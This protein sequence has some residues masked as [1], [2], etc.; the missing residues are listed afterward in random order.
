MF[1]KFK[2][3]RSH[4]ILLIQFCSFN[5]IFVVLTCLDNILSTVHTLSIH[6]Q[7]STIDTIKYLKLVETTKAELG[8][9]RPDEYFSNFYTKFEITSSN[10]N[11]SL[12]N[13]KQQ[14]TNIN[15]TLTDYIITSTTGF[16]NTDITIQNMRVMYLTVCNEYDPS[17]I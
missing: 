16:K 15:S 6:L 17:T 5:I 14:H 7:S 11:I 9:W 2:K 13:Y 1:K 10:L 4:R 8:R 12:S 3:E